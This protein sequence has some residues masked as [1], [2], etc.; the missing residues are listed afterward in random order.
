MII[1]W[2]WKKVELRTLEVYIIYLF[3]LVTLHFKCRFLFDLGQIFSSKILRNEQMFD[4][5]GT[6]SKKLQFQ[7]IFFAH[8]SEHNLTRD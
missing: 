7:F 1:E 4:R 5:L 2:L 6:S 3:L 8:P